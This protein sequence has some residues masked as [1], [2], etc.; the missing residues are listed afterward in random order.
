MHLNDA[1]FILALLLTS[2]LLSEAWKP[3]SRDEAVVACTPENECTLNIADA[4][5]K[6]PARV[7]LMSEQRLVSSD[8][9][10]VCT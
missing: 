5:I 3:T 2:C 8:L 1:I 9:E 6:L 7:V 4:T 10:A